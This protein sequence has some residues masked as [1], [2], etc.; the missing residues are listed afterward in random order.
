MPTSALTEF[1]YRTGVFEIVTDTGTPFWYTCTSPALNGSVASLRWPMLS[2]TP[3]LK[4]WVPV[5]YETAPTAN[6]RVG[7][8]SV[9]PSAGAVVSV[10]REV[11]IRLAL[12]NH[13]G[14]PYSFFTP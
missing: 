13:S 4:L 6:R 2:C 12:A 8:C 3:N 1:E 11:S 5:T 7:A 10:P 9:S 14:E